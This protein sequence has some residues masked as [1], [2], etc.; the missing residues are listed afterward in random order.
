MCHDE[1]RK[2]SPVARLSGKD[3]SFLEEVSC[4]SMAERGSLEKSLIQES[5]V[6]TAE[7]RLLLQQRDHTFG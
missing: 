7:S 5:L 6:E 2:I 3:D 1:D 4:G